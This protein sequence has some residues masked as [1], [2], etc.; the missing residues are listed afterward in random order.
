M[1]VLSEG[2]DLQ[3]VVEEGRGHLQEVLVIGVDCIIFNDMHRIYSRKNCHRIETW[4]ALE[5]CGL[6]TLK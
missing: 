3:I 2:A 4:S 6:C 5:L 1:Y